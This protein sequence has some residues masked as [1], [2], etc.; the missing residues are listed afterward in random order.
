MRI[1]TAT[2]DPIKDMLALMTGNI[3]GEAEGVAAPVEA[4]VMP[5]MPQQ[6]AGVPQ[7]SSG[8]NPLRSG[9]DAYKEALGGDIA[10]PDPPKAPTKKDLLLEALISKIPVYG[11]VHSAVKQYERQAEAAKYQQAVNDYMKQA[12]DMR[13]VAK[14]GAQKMMENSIEREN[15]QRKVDTQIAL[16]VPVQQAMVNAGFFKETE[17]SRIRVVTP[18]SG[19]QG[20]PATAFKGGDISFLGPNGEP[21]LGKPGMDPMILQT[22]P[23]KTAQEIVN[24]TKDHE[25]IKKVRGIEAYR[26]EMGMAP[27]TD[28]QRDQLFGVL[29]KEAAL[30]EIETVGPGGDTV[31]KFVTPTEGMTFPK[32]KKEAQQ[33]LRLRNY[34]NP[35]T[36]KN[37]SVWEY[38]QEGDIKERPMTQ[39]QSERVKSVG[40]IRKIAQQLMDMSTR[41]VTDNNA[42]IQ[43]AKAA[44]M[45]I[46]K[47]ATNNPEFKV[48]TDIVK[49]L[50]FMIARMQESG[51]ISDQDA[52]IWTVALPD[53]WSDTVDSMRL[54][55]QIANESS[56][57]ELKLPWMGKPTSGQGGVS[58]TE[59]SAIEQQLGTKLPPGAK[60]TRIQ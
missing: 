32:P 28:Q 22:L 2:S 24:E 25:L 46:E 54:K 52:K 36:G 13:S 29:A 12:D 14:H 27:L 6:R 37:E 19:P 30:K 49:Q 26:A 59:K 44:G 40:R 50:G 3:G 8:Q 43:R 42:A 33:T 57:L 47:Y 10:M 9:L 58:D 60:I 39:A 7:I 1:N 20:M 31:G 56:D 53:V 38:P 48:Y 35:E 16:G 41:I 34:F 55:W 23:E 18:W 15:M 11:G 17:S 51:R 21:M 4:E 45:T 5:P